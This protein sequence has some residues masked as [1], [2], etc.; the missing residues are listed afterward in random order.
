MIFRKKFRRVFYVPGN[1]APG[2][3]RIVDG[4]IQFSLVED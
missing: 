2:Q 3:Q 4:R 1:H